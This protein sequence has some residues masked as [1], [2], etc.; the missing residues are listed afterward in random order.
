M[1]LM[2][3][4]SQN[5]SQV[6]N[7][8]NTQNIDIIPIADSAMDLGST[9]LWY[10]EIFGDNIKTQSLKLYDSTHAE[11]AHISR[12]LT[13]LI[14]DTGT[15]GLLQFVLAGTPIIDISNT[16]INTDMNIIP[17]TSGSVI[18]GSVNYWYGEV[19]AEAIHI[20]G[21]GCWDPT[22]TASCEFERTLTE[23]IMD[24]G[25]GANFFFNVKGASAIELSSTTLKSYLDIVPSSTNS[26]D[27]GSE[28]TRWNTIFVQDIITTNIDTQ[29]LDIFVYTREEKASITRVLGLDHEL[30]IDTGAGSTELQIKLAGVVGAI[31][32]SDGFRTN[33]LSVDTGGKINLEGVSGDTYIKFNSAQSRIEFYLNNTLEGYV[34]N[35]GFVSV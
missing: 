35:T 25:S 31:L 14:I 34:D 28:G 1:P 26:K 4:G 30:I 10:H 29:T 15:G 18:I 19:F 7:R 12:N 13:N 9:S 16:Q 17:K 23:M 32:D 20:I 2:P 21:L 6:L 22:I 3:T 33:H 8:G 5:L 24:S 11:S 27:L